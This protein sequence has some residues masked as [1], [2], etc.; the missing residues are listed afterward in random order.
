MTAPQFNIETTNDRPSASAVAIASAS[1][2]A[3]AEIQA[4]MVIAKKYPRD[5][6]VAFAKI[7]RACKRPTLADMATY[8]Y[9]RGGTSISGPSIHLAKVIA[10][11]WGNIQ[12]GWRE[13]D[14]REGVS[15]CEAFAWDIE[16][17]TYNAIAFDV[18][19]W[20]DTKQGGYALKDERDIY[21]LCANQSARR[22]RA[23]LLSVTPG[24]VVDA[25]LAE[26]EATLKAGA[27]SEP[28][29]DR[30]RKM[31]VAFEQFGV[32]VEMLE[33]R[34]GHKLAALTEPELAKLKKVFTSLRDGV[35]VREDFF[36]AES[37]KPIPPGDPAADQIPGAEVPAKPKPAKVP[38]KE[39]APEESITATAAAADGSAQ[40]VSGVKAKVAELL[41]DAGVSFGD[42]CDWLKA[43]GTYEQSDSL[44]DVHAL[45]IDIADELLAD[46]CKRLRKCIT[47]HGRKG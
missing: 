17:N 23:C 32:S 10:Q 19:H 1:S 21:E 14:R 26:C 34:L 6:N 11:A 24:D 28:L 15:T 43:T 38:K 22:M 31:A 36:T 27:G 42:F 8:E 2:K 29:Q 37:T 7:M 3:T 9:S 18:K 41:K 47:L 5:E 16:T 30:A 13:V 44:P 4:A 12:F 40:P 45:P 20:R 46:N 25:A 39:T 35:G 33:T